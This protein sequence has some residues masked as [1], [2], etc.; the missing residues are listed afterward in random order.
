MVCQLKYTFWYRVSKVPFK[1]I[2]RISELLT[3][4]V[5]KVSFFWWVFITQQTL[6]AQKNNNPY[7]LI[8]MCIF[9]TLLSMYFMSYRMHAINYFASLGIYMRQGRR[10]Q[11]QQNH[12]LWK[13]S[14]DQGRHLE[15]SV[16]AVM[17]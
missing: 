7:S 13:I 1:V 2:C 10:T 4:Y 6:Y 5:I 8:F 16:E 11:R 9:S 14:N 12:G 3:K 15:K 17:I